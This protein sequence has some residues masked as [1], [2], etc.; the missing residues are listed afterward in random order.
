MQSYAKSGTS[1]YASSAKIAEPEDE[2]DY[3]KVKLEDEVEYSKST[4]KDEVDYSKVK[5]CEDSTACAKLAQYLDKS[6]SHF[7]LSDSM[8]SLD[9][10]ASLHNEKVRGIR[11]Y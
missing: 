4:P 5:Y 2:V 7:C 10:D 9:L 3:S 8:K 11:W 1:P 6:G